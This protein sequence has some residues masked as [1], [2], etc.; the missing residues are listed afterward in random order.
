MAATVWKPDHTQDVL[1]F[2]QSGAA[3]RTVTR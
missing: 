3:L 2:P 1:R